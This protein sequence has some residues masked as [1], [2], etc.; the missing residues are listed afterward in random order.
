MIF[1]VKYYV[2]LSRVNVR[3]SDTAIIQRI[4]IYCEMIWKTS[5]RVR[6]II[7]DHNDNGY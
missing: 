4:V 2:G 3:A 5:K 7:G 6:F 1:D